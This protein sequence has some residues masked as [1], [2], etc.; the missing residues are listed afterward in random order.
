MMDNRRDTREIGTEDGSL[1]D[2]R[3]V[4]R[5]TRLERRDTLKMGKVEDGTLREALKLMNCFRIVSVLIQ[6]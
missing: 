4:T 3:Q 2:G 1:G 6:A 5:G